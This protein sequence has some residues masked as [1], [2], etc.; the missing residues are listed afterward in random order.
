MGGLS[1]LIS[2]VREGESSI[3][4]CDL[5]LVPLF[6]GN[7]ISKLHM[8]QDHYHETAGLYLGTL[9]ARKCELEKDYPYILKMKNDL[10]MLYEEQ[11]AYDK[12]EPLLIETIEGRRL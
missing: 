8:A 9:D 3:Y 5:N 11:G 7:T 12:S 6:V 4:M 1:A 2:Q 10:V